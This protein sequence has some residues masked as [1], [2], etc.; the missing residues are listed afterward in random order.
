M[1]V[2]LPFAQSKE[3]T[4]CFDLQCTFVMAAIN[5]WLRMMIPIEGKRTDS[6]SL[7]W[8]EKIH[9]PNIFFSFFEGVGVGVG[10]CE[11]SFAI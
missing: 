8:T 6:K 7:N 4:R 2:C 3:Y 11:I 1:Y 10:V 9:L 5:R